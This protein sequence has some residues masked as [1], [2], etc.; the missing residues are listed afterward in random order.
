MKTEAT[1]IE[2]Y[3]NALPPDRRK[4][5]Q[6]VRK[7]IL[8]NLP[9]GYEET[10]N[11]G[12]I[13]YEVPLETHPNTYNRQPLMYAALASQ[14]HHM[15]VYLTGIYTSDE[16]RGKFEKAYAAT[17]KKPDIGKS[18]VRFKRLDG[19]P[20]ELIGEAIASMGVEE[21]IAFTEEAGSVRKSRKA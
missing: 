6:T 3:L 18:C 10:F 7:V 12:M 5:I 8:K 13:S 14:K 1:S 20:L 2:E 15:A 17:G 11:W 16:A 21:F 19:L 4:A 9:K